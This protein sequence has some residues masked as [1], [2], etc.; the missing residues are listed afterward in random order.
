ME[1]NSGKRK[2]NTDTSEMSVRWEMNDRVESIEN[3][4]KREIKG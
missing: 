4:H 1:V 3:K 2:K